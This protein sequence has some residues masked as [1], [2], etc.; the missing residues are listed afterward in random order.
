[1]ANLINVSQK[2]KKRQTRK[3]L[4]DVTNKENEV[5][6]VEESGPKEPDNSEIIEL[7][8]DSAVCASAEVK[9]VET[10]DEFLA[11]REDFK[12]ELKKGFRALFEAFEESVQSLYD[13]IDHVVVG[14]AEE[15]KKE[16]ESFFSETERRFSAVE[17]EHEKGG[18]LKKTI[19]N[20]LERLEKAFSVLHEEGFSS[21]KSKPT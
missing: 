18:E 12:T 1:M 20:M 9:K 6:V 16:Q 3:A 15:L 2:G 4:G 5:F 14:F 7:F 13:K 19:Q 11:N 8:D 17:E 21:E 10:S